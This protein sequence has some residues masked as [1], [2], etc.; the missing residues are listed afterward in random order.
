VLEDALQIRFP[1]RV[2]SFSLAGRT[3]FPDKGAGAVIAYESPS[4][5]GAVYVY[6]AGM[7]NIPTGAA[8]PC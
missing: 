3:A 4:V 5:R 7:S 2:G 8:T 6:D 1:D